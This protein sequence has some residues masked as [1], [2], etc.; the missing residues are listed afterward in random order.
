MNVY[1]NNTCID[2]NSARASKQLKQKI[3][4]REREKRDR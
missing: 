4:V 3:K 2:I 1:K